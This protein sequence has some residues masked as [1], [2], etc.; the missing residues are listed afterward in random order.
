MV[1]LGTKAQ[2]K[3]MIP[4]SVIDIFRYEIALKHET[5]TKGLLSEETENAINNYI[6]LMRMERKQQQNTNMQH[7]KEIGKFFGFIQLRDK[8]FK[9]MID[10]G[11]WEEPMQYIPDKFLMEAIG[12]IRGTDIRTVNGW[13]NKLKQ[14]GIIE[15]SGIHEYMFCNLGGES[16]L[17]TGG[18]V[19]IDR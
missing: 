2:F 8:I 1:F 16:S 17:L 9:Y 5:I 15:Q 4:K 19:E 10:R 11:Y 6:V 13:I 12:V 14:G 7:N 3:V 18:T